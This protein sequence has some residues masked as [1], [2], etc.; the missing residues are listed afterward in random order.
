MK[1]IK[2]IPLICCLLI[3]ISC[4]SDDDGNARTGFFPNEIVLTTNADGTSNTTSFTYNTNNQIAEA[5]FGGQIVTF[6][7]NE[8]GLINEFNV[9]SA[10]ESY[11]IQYSGS[12]VVSFTNL[13][14]NDVIPVSYTDGTYDFD[15]STFT[16]D[17]NN[18]FISGSGTLAVTYNEEEGPFTEVAFQPVLFFIGA[19]AVARISYFFSVNEVNSFTIP[20]GGELTCTTTRNSDGNISSVAAR[21]GDGTLIYTY[22]MSY[23]QRTI[24]N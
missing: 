5:N 11:S 23:E 9:G 13:D 8:Q 7:Y 17:A 14:T 10:A 4:S 2:L 1:I 3:L 21:S 20:L 18:R 22:T 16:L 6:S 12:T 24:N 15:G 19:G